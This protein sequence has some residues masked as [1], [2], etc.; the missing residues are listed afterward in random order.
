MSLI[1]ERVTSRCFRLVKIVYKKE[2]VTHD[3]IPMIQ[4]SRSVY[5]LGILIKS[6]V[7]LRKPSLRDAFQLGY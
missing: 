4:E 2:S 1:C 6:Q 5:V 3:K 7:S